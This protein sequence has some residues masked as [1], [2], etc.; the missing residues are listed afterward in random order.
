[1]SATFLDGQKYWKGT[2]PTEK[3]SILHKVNVDP[4]QTLSIVDKGI[5]N[6]DN[7]RYITKWSG[8]YFA[9]I[10]NEN[11]GKILSSDDTKQWGEIGNG[12]S[13]FTYFKDD[14]KLLVGAG[15]SVYLINVKNNNDGF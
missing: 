8:V 4:S 12:L 1:M 9:G 13:S 15:L 11:S 10:V 5:N 6:D 7:V 2:D 14:E 3:L